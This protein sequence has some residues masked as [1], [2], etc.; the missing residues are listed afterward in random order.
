MSGLFGSSSNAQSK[1]VAIAALNIQQSCYSTPVPICYGTNRVSG[2]MI[3]YGDFTAVQV[4]TNSSSGKG[5][6]FSTGGGS[7]Y[8]YNYYSSFMF[9]LCEGPIKGVGT[10]WVSK[11]VSDLS[12]QGGVVFNGDAGQSPWGYLVSKHPDQADSYSGLAHMDFASYGLGTSAETPQFSAQVYGLLSFENEYAGQDALADE[13]ILDFLDKCNFPS[14]YLDDLT[15][16]RNYWLS[17]GFFISPCC[18]EQ[19]SAYDWLQEWMDTLNA[20]FV[21]N[22]GK[23]SVVPYADSP[24]SGNGTSYTP[25]MTPIYDLTDDDFVFSEDEDPVTVEREDM[26][27]A[28]NRLPIEYTNEAN[29]YNIETYTAEDPAHIDLYGVR[30]ASTLSCHHVSD[31]NIAQAMAHIALW[32]KI[33]I[34]KGNTYKFKLPWNFILLDPMDLVTITDEGLGLTKKLVRIKQIDESDEDG[35]LSFEAEDVPGQIALPALYATQG[36][37]RHTNDYNISPGSVNVPIIFE[38]P[39]KLVQSSSVELS[40]AVSGGINWGGCYVYVSTDDTT[41]QN[42]GTIVSKA[43]TGKLTAELPTFS[44][45]TTTID[46]TNTLSVD[47]LESNGSFNNAATSQDALLFNTLC[48]VDGELISYGN[49]TLTGA[50]K[51]DLTYLNRGCYGSNI[52]AHHVDS[53]FVRYDT[54]VLRYAIDETRVGQTLYFKFQ[55]FNHYNGGVE[56]LDQLNSYAYQVT[57][58]ALLSPLG[59]PTD[60]S[61]VYKDK[62][63]QINWT[64][65][66]D[67][68]SPIMYEVRKGPTFTSA[69]YVGE[70][71]NATFPVYGNGTYWVAAFYATPSGTIVYSANP[72]SIAITTSSIH[73]NIIESWNEYST[74]WTGTKTNCSVLSGN[75]TTSPGVTSA[76]YQI[77]SAHQISSNYVCSARVNIN[78]NGSAVGAETDIV[79]ITDITAV[80]DITFA[81]IQ[82]YVKVIPQIR[83]SQDGGTTWTDWQNWVAG[84]Y[85]FNKIDFR[86]LIEIKNTLYQ[87]QIGEFNYTVDVDYLTQTGTATSSASSS[88]AVSFANE[89]NSVPHVSPTIIGGSTGDQC[90]I[91]TVSSSGFTFEVRNGGSLVARTVSWSA[92]GE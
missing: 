20:S 28:Y 43:R 18:D 39:L 73:E 6:L 48:Y 37:V 7:S 55:S 62:F 36:T 51:Y 9:G 1:P 72:Q 2:N 15:N 47:M 65:V 22:G 64:P 16:A 38:T 10:V 77:P 42:V 78:W 11:V 85:Q 56:S 79:S 32:R 59:N 45:T 12:S 40:I 81:S 35:T 54:T 90:N 89:F 66:S 91:L 14:D 68:R 26:P 8:E 76:T 17:M 57:G 88:V 5:G 52:G 60:L 63:A 23:L 71:T 70:T 13:V 83:L 19:R 33:Y 31:P 74:G 30:T 3:W 25:D 29:E 69:Q 92:T 75:L 34:E 27:D 80:P 86:L 61:Y 24:V 21:W 4:S 44:S 53:E 46:Q 87:A 50:N 84:V 58:A 82:E 49:D 41:Y 67:V